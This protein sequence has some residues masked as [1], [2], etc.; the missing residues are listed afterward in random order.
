VCAFDMFDGRRAEITRISWLWSK[1]LVAAYNDSSSNRFGIIFFALSN[2][3]HNKPHSGID[4]VS[5]FDSG[6]TKEILWMVVPARA[7]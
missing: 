5:R 4:F 6:H 1:L 3:T 2:F 7:D